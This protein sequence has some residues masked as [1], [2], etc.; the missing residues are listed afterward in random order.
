MER[1]ENAALI[2]PHL[3]AILPTIDPEIAMANQMHMV[4]LGYHGVPIREVENIMTDAT[5]QETTVERSDPIRVPI[6]KAKG[7]FFDLEP[8]RLPLPV[9]AAVFAA[10]AKVFLNKGQT[11]ITK[12][13]YPNPADLKAAA[14]LKAEET[15]EA[16]YAGTIRIAGGAKSDKVPREV[17]TLARNKAK[18]IVKQQIK[19]AG[20]RISL[21]PPKD[22]TAAANSMLASN[23]ELIEQAREDWEKMRD[24]KVKGFDV[25]TL[26]P[27]KELEAAF[28]RKKA[29]KVLSAAKSGQVAA[30][31]R[32]PGR[33]ATH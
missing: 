13:A 4:E 27:S 8:D 31:G 26:K 6:V 22:I 32:P 30:R 18:A 24:L 5:V 28:E 15:L 7:E 9:F 20:M 16:M 2:P 11:K 17:M 25:S 29:E 12:A 3:C 1:T 33:P 23:P 21:F 14:L 19:D 10:G